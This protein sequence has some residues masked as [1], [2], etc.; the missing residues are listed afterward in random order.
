M[1]FGKIYF[2][3]KISI[4]LFDEN[5]N[6]EKDEIVTWNEHGNII[7]CVNKKSS[8]RVLI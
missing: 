3:K 5:E 7:F 4:R 6:T 2:N 1:N 8:S